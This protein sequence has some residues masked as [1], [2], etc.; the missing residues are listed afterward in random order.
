LDK[1]INLIKKL[2]VKFMEDFK[3]CPKCGGKT[4]I[5]FY[6]NDYGSHRAYCVDCEFEIIEYRF[7]DLLKAWNSYKNN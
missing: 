1:S 6:C 4:K 3:P 2:E 5:E 7:G